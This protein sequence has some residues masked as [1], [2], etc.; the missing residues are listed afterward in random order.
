VKIIAVRKRVESFEQFGREQ[1]MFLHDTEDD[2]LGVQILDAQGESFEFDLT[3]QQAIDV[4]RRLFTRALRLSA[5]TA[6]GRLSAGIAARL[7]IQQTQA[8][9]ERTRDG[10][11]R[12]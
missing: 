6:N 12:A 4:A 2:N 9:A 10:Q 11:A 1:A 8:A 3:P 7:M 5:H